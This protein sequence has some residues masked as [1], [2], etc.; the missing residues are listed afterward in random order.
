MVECLLDFNDMLEVVEANNNPDGY[1]A[2]DTE[3]NGLDIRDGTGFCI[4]VGVAGRFLSSLDP[5]LN[6]KVLSGYYPFRHNV[7]TNLEVLDKYRLKN[8]LENFQGWL[9]F[10]N[11]KFDLESLRTLGINYKGKFWDT[12]LMCHIINENFPYSKD[13][14]SCVRTYVN[15]ND[16]KKDTEEFNLIVKMAGWAN[17]PVEIM[18]DYAA[19]DPNLTLRL[20]EKIIN[21]YGKEATLEFWDHKQDLVRCIIAME[22]RGVLVD[23]AL[24]TRMS[25]IGRT[26]MDETEQLLGYNLAS[27]IDLEK[28]FI[29]DLKLPIIK[30]G[31]SRPSFNKEVM[32][33]YEQILEHRNGDETA[34]TVLTFRGWQKAVTSNY[35]PYITLLSHDGRLR[36]NYKLHGTK[37]GRSSCTDPNLQQIPRSTTKEWNG[38]MKSCFIPQLGF[39]LWGADYSQL[40]FRLGAAYGQQK[41]LLD[42]FNAEPPRDIFEEMSKDLGENRYDTKQITYTIQYGAGYKKI[43]WR[44]GRPE[45]EGKAIKEKFYSA[46]PGIKKVSDM[47]TMVVRVKGKVKLWSGRYRHFAFPSDEAYK[48]FNSVGQGG[49]A[50]LFNYTMVRCFKEIDNE[51]ECRMLLMIH[52]E[53]VWE[54]KNGMEDHYLPLIKNV[55]ENGNPDF[56]VKF[57]VDIHPWGE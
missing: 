53:I 26:Q 25:I 31:K 32:E 30:M 49:A 33:E 44:L 4:G 13:L 5:S 12:M 3:T 56:G 21:L 45:E 7:G 46:Y 6:S 28:L 23:K 22:R 1:I 54:I 14:T 38:K 57:R 52:D 15:K 55:M 48:A 2:I 16:G 27:P 36:C 41:N 42:I 40:E 50:D 9:I 8:A 19:Y 29:Q 39:S 18:T 11:S 35:E 10:H 34:K 37:T 20:F 24:C 43:A 51:A 47:A 17:V